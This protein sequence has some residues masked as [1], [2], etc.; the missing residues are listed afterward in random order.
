MSSLSEVSMLLGQRAGDLEKAR[1]IF[2]AEIKSFAENVLGGI[3]RARSEP[4]MNGRVRV[5]LPR[6]VE[7]ESRAGYLSSHSALA[8]CDLRFR[9][10]ARFVQIAEVRFGIEFDD[11]ADAFV[12]QVELVPADRY[13]RVDDFVWR[14]WQGAET[15]DMPGSSRQERANTVRFV[16]R[17]LDASLA[18]QVAFDDI[19]KILEFL[20]ATG[21]PLGEAVGLDL[22]PVGTPVA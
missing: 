4:W 10:E 13:P 14:A 16:A 21:G 7:A 19:K 1:D 6:E 11:V 2:V 15:K 5:D 18:S 8:R 20:L 22:E 17:P 9:R 12:W 3:R